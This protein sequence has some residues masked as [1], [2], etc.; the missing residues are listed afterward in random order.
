M[1]INVSL[2]A[3]NPFKAAVFMMS[4]PV[5]RRVNGKK[6]R[7]E[8]KDVAFVAAL[9]GKVICCCLLSDHGLFDETVKLPVLFKD[10]FHSYNNNNTTCN[11]RQ[12][13]CDA[14]LE[15]I[16]RKCILFPFVTSRERL[17]D[18]SH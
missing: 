3:F 9:K 6:D 5:N 1:L 11:N 13:A 8:A 2:D 15:S 18:E 10:Y 17:E 12:L 7:R 14:D 4:L 16:A